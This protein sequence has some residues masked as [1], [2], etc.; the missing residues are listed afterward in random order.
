MAEQQ[1]GVRCEKVTL[2]SEGGEGEREGGR[3]GGRENKLSSLCVHVEPFSY[4]WLSPRTDNNALTLVFIGSPS[5]FI[6]R[7]R[8]LQVV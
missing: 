3:E 1:E 6:R 5:Q 7:L 4:G 2:M 8:V